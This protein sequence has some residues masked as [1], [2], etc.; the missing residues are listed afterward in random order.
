MDKNLYIYLLQ[1]LTKGTDSW[2][3][4][5]VVHAIVLLAHFHSLASFVFSCGI[6]EELDNVAVHECKKC[7][8]DIKVE[9]AKENLPSTPKKIPHGS[10]KTGKKS[11]QRKHS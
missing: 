6:R 7:A 11:W 8:V 5:E 10:G 9:P 4:A 3:L 1:R 2:S